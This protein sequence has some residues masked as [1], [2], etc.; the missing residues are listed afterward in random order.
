MLGL[1]VVFSLAF[2]LF[3]QRDL[4]AVMNLRKSQQG[5]L[6][7]MQANLRSALQD[8]ARLSTA[9]GQ[10]LSWSRVLGEVLRAPFGPAPA[11]RPAAPQISA[12]LPRCAQVG[13]ADPGAQ[14][15]GD[16]VHDIQRRLYA[17]GWLTQPWQTLVV[18]AAARLREEPEMLYRMPGIGTGSGLDQW[19]AAVAAGQVQS[20]GAD[21]LWARVED[22]FAADGGVGSA[23][24]ETVRVPALARQ[25]RAQEFGAGFVD[26][27][28][29]RAAPFDSATFT[30]SA[31]TAGRSAVAVDS[32]FLTRAGLGYRAVVVQAS[33]GVAPYDLTLFEM[34]VEFAAG[35]DDETTTL[36]GRDQR[37]D[38]RPGQDMVF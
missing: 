5:R 7:T 15:A 18:D 3:A 36:I 24:T 8:V 38:T 16:A 30:D 22:M 17:L 12:G 21:A 6:E 34:P 31:V 32:A 26:H 27:R 10:L 19:S 29:G 13:F 4:F 2:F 20:S 33:D 25:M 9:Y 28:P 11:T 37:P 1:Y 14:Q 23:L 35:I